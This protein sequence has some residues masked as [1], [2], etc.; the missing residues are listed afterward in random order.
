MKLYNY[1]RSGTSYRVR[2]AL[3]LKE[4]EYEYIPIN[5]R[6]AEQ[7]N[8]AYLGLNPQGLVPSLELDNGTVITQSPAILDYLEEAFPNSPLLPSSPIDRAHVRAM[9]ALIGCDVHPLNNLRILKYLKGELKQDQQGVDQW[10]ARWIH[11]GF[12]A[13][14]RLLE[15]AHNR[16]GFCFG[17]APGLAECYL[18]PQVYSAQRFNVDLSA[19]PLITEIEQKCM[20]LAAFQK[21]YPDKQMDAD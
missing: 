8:A 13:L 21:A 20:T 10:I 9:A 15:S 2:I 3:A 14:E 19:Y 16:D 5:L 18:L 17:A 12:N 11:E 7:K 4:I 1:W 6:D